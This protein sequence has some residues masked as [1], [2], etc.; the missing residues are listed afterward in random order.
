METE[1]LKLCSCVFERLGDAPPSDN[2]EFLRS[3]LIAIFTSLHFY[4]NNTRAKVIPAKIMK[5]VHIFFANF[6]VVHGSLALV[7]ACNQIQDG[8][9]FMV[10]TSESKALG[11]VSNPARDRKYVLVAYSRLLAECCD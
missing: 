10:L 3:V 11:H 4:R 2:G 6:M 9:L 7:N 1:A 5:A 8:S